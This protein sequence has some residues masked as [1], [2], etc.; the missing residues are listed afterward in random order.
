MRYE[1]VRAPASRPRPGR[2]GS[3]G[4]PG[5]PQRVRGPRGQKRR[6]LMAAVGAGLRAYTRFA[7]VDTPTGRSCLPNATSERVE[8]VALDVMLDEIFGLR[9]AAV[10]SVDPTTRLYILW[11]G[12]TRPGG[13]RSMKTANRP[14]LEC[15]DLHLDVLLE[16]LSE[17]VFAL[18]LSALA[19]HLIGRDLGLPASEL[20][21]VPAVYRDADSFFG[22]S[23]L[24]GGLKSLLEDMPGRLVGSRGRQPHAQAADPVRRREVAHLGHF[25]PRCPVAGRAGRPARGDRAAPP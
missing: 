11:T 23:Y 12:G 16:E 17:D 15:V 8:G 1:A 9:G 14:W 19:G 25:A 2:A 24:T 3:C 22:A 4:P 18:D 10:G 6:L 13:L 21:R 5:L 7:R 20:P